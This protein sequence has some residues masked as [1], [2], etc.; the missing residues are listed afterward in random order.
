MIKVY[1]GKRKGTKVVALRVAISLSPK[2]Y[3]FGTGVV[4]QTKKWWHLVSVMVPINFPSV[5]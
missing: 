5:E 3:H 1:T 2:E 4:L